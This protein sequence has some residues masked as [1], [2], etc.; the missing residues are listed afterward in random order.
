MARKRI[1]VVSG[2]AG[3]GKSTAARA[4]EDLGYFV[5]DNLPP[6]LIET[7]VSLADSAGGELRRIALIVDA[8]ES[9][10]LK[11]FG[12]IWDRLKATEHE[13]TLLFLDCT[14]DVLIRRFKETRRRHPLDRGDGVAEAI[15][16]ERGLLDDL[17]QRA[18]WILDTRDSSVHDLK[19][20]VA[21][22][23]AE[24]ESRTP[25]LTLMSFGFKHGLP[26]ELDLCFD[27]RFLPNPY[28]IEDLRPQTGK[29]A[30]VRD[31][32]LGQEDAQ[33]FLDKAQDMAE[34]LL[35][36][37]AQE[38]KS[39]VTLAIG[40]TGGKHRSVALTEALA[41]RLEGEERPVRVVHRDVGKN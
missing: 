12:P 11:D 41:K 10:F 39:Y 18:D 29:D 32:V 13:L 4:L 25:Q 5:V 24:A 27:V 40:C 9:G 37:Y 20:E 31:Y 30:P 15:T 7:L 28:F 16:R 1:V 35:P 38:G 26:P 3:A 22:R 33:Q 21:E 17:R 36:R 14:D 23:F 34:F 2:L 6:L 19:R 8:R